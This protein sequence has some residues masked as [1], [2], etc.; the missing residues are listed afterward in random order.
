MSAHCLGRQQVQSQPLVQ[1]VDQCVL[2]WWK[3]G[4]S[5]RAGREQGHQVSAHKKSLVM[6]PTP[7]HR[8]LNYMGPTASQQQL[9][10]IPMD[11]GGST[12]S[13]HS[14]MQLCYGAPSIEGGWGFRGILGDWCL[15][16]LG[17]EPT[18]RE[19][20]TS[21]VCIGKSTLFQK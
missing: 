6:G 13:N 14:R 7:S 18:A 5:G 12:Q 21:G 2:K 4:L 17:V 1:P 20:P 16:C 3:R 10:Y 11:I 8:Q 19:V 15:S 9:N